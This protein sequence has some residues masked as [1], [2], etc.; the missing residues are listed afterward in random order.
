[1]VKSPG[2]TYKG[3]GYDFKGPGYMYK[4]PGYDYKG[5]GWFRTS[6]G[7]MRGS[8][9]PVYHSVLKGGAGAAVGPE[10]WQ[11]LRKA[12]PILALLKKSP[13]LAPP[14]PPPVPP[15]HPKGP[16][17]VYS[18][19]PKQIFVTPVMMTEK[20]LTQAVNQALNHE[21]PPGVALFEN[22]KPTHRELNNLRDENAAVGFEVLASMFH[23][24]FPVD[25]PPALQRLG[26]QDAYFFFAL[27]QMT[28]V[29]DRKKLIGTDFYV[30]GRDYLFA[31]Q[32]DDG[33]WHGGYFT[34]TIDTSFGILFLRRSNLL[35]EATERMRKLVAE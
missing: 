11:G 6:P 31:A 10:R 15:P 33:A 1:M 35:P 24:A 22:F 32:R 8:W 12:D 5:P 27:Q 34:N 20:L 26:P 21:L 30:W 16:P 4:G 18:Y 17:I 13:H 14:A 2:Y 7:W 28:A 9:D 29:H 23:G 25:P 3:P 19:R